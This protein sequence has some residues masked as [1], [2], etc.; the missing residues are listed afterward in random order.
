VAVDGLLGDP[1]ALCD[2]VHRCA[3]ETQRQ[4][5]LAG[6]VGLSGLLSLLLT[7]AAYFLM[8]RRSREPVVAWARSTS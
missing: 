8:Q 7:P 1:R 3:L 4:K 5:A 2:L 6:G